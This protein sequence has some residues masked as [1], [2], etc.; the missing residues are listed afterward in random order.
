[1]G[2]ISLFSN[3]WILLKPT[4]VF[5]FIFILCLW[6]QICGFWSKLQICGSMFLY[7]LKCLYDNQLWLMRATLKH[8]ELSMIISL[9]VFFIHLSSFEP[10]YIALEVDWKVDIEN[11]T[12]FI[13][14]L[15]P[16]IWLCFL[17]NLMD[18]IT[19]KWFRT[20]LVL[21]F[22]CNQPFSMVYGKILVK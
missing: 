12:I 15:I 1:M 3:L 13:W 20:F 4:T 18:F 21:T 10:G 22:L 7:Y 11:F 9:Q 6:T 16:Q 14:F 8:G 5:I 2:F 17:L 19:K